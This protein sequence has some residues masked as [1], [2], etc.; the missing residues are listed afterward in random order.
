MV[1]PLQSNFPVPQHHFIPWMKADMLCDDICVIDFESIEEVTFVLPA[2]PP[3]GS[4]LHQNHAQFPDN[5]DENKYYIV[6]PPHSKWGEI[7]WNQ[8]EE[9]IMG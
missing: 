8:A 2:M 9:T 3:R 5:P 6:I 4:P 1:Q 7:G